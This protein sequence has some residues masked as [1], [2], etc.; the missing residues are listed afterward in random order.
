MG[1]GTKTR[2]CGGKKN[3]VH[4]LLGKNQETGEKELLGLGVNE[5]W[6]ETVSQFSGKA[7]VAVS[8]NEASLRVVLLEK[9]VEY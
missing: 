1:D 5:S 8:D 6:R 2:G 7:E 3:E 9:S 4:V